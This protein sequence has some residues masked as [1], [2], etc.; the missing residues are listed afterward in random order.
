MG[1]WVQNLSDLGLFIFGG[2]EGWGKKVG[3]GLIHPNDPTGPYPREG[4]LGLH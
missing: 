4:V 3:P 2:G 1:P